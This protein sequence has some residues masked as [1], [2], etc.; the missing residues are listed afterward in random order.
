[1]ILT[2]EKAKE[3]LRTVTKELYT[4]YGLATLSKKDPKYIAVYEGDGFRRDMSYH[5]GI[6]WPWL[7]GLYVESFK[8][9]IKNE[10]N[11]TEKKK[12]EEEYEKIIS[13]YKK[14]FTQAM[15][16][17]ALGTISEL[18]DSKPPYLPKGAF[19]QAWSV[20]EVIKI[21]LEK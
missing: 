17:G 18:Y 10:K 6:T 9:I 2:N 7:A 21:M 12:L 16:E 14:S 5:Q 15:K 19:A 20:S 1:M 8:T 4:K 3:M 11:K 13:N